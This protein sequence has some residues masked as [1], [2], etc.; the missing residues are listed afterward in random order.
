[1]LVS[2]MSVAV[3]MIK[4]HPGVGVTNVSGCID[5]VPPPWC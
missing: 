4:V 2:L 1:V 3:Y 5:G